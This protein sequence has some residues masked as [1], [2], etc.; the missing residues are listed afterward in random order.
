M[1]ALLSAVLV[2]AAGGFALRVIPLLAARHLP[3]EVSDIAAW[4]GLAAIVALIV[5]AVAGHGAGPGGPLPASVAL[6][7]AM[8]LACRGRPVLVA[9]PVGVAAYI[10][11]S[12]LGTV[13]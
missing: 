1:N 13:T 12:G 4:A 10:V 3:D 6:V 5:R 9:L 7:I 2:V 11:A 8:A